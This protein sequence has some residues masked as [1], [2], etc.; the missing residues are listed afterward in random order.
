MAPKLHRASLAV[1]MGSQVG[2]SNT[3]SKTLAC[4]WLDPFNLNLFGLK[5]VVD[6]QDRQELFRF[7]GKTPFPP[8]L[9]LHR[10]QSWSELR[11]ATFQ[12]QQRFSESRRHWEKM[13]EAVE[14]EEE[15]WACSSDS[16]AVCFEAL[17]LEILHCSQEV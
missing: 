8:N 17:P 3:Q 2:R 6:S 5:R 7:A 10:G 1:N 15:E 14:A 13:C 12:S 16:C 9:H 4:V 11:S